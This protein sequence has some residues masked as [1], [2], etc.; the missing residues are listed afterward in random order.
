MRKMSAKN[1]LLN[2]SLL[3]LV[4]ILFVVFASEDSEAATHT[5]DKIGGSDY[6]NITHAVENASAG[7]TIRVASR[8][9]HDAVDANKKLNFIGGN[10]GVDL[11]YLYDC[12]EGDMVAKYSLDETNPS[13]VEDG[14][15]C[16]DINGDVEGATTAVGLWGNGLDFDGTN[17]YVE[18]ADDSAF[19]SEVISIT[20]WVN[21]DDNDTDHRTIFSKYESTSGSTKGYKTLVSDDAKFQFVFGWGSDHGSC[22]SVKDIPENTWTLLTATYDKSSIKL[23]IDGELDNSCGYSN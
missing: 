10:Y 18:I 17:D 23:Y 6:T 3:L 11:G 14:V 7:D 4:A 19:D 12:N 2:A 1:R 20:A 5:V 13:E 16:H 9:Y 21:I 15:W 8:N 22:S